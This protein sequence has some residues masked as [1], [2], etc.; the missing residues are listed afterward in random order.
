MT[1]HLNK[2]D[3]KVSIKFITIHFLTI[4]YLYVIKVLYG[5]FQVLITVDD[6]PNTVQKFPK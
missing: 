2:N 3:L 1:T 6:S 4:S 5:T